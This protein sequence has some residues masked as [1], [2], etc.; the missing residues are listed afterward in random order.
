VTDRNPFRDQRVRDALYRAIDASSLQRRAMRGLSRTTGSL[1]APAIPGYVPALDQRPGFDAD[2]ARK[3]LTEAGYPHG[4]SVLMNCNNDSL[5]DEEELCQAVAS[6]WS[7]IGLKP[8]VSIG[9]RA[10]QMPK[11]VKGEF[12]L[13]PFGWANEP[14]IDACSLLVQVIRSRN[15]TGGVFNWGNPRIDALI[16]QSAWNWTR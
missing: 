11:R 2:A 12:D 6:M 7:R 10:Q 16:E 1:I 3:L 14:Q 15:P 8:N 9:P 4:F 5:V 13:I